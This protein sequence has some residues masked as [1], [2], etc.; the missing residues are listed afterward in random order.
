MSDCKDFIQMFLRVGG[1]LTCKYDTKQCNILLDK[2]PPKIVC[3]IKS[4]DVLQIDFMLWEFSAGG[5]HHITEIP[6]NKNDKMPEKIHRFQSENTNGFIIK[7]TRDKDGY[8]K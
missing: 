5:S 6:L 3:D 7:F 2:L 1:E 8:Y 4:E